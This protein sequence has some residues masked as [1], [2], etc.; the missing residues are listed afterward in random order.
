MPELRVCIDVPDLPRAIEFYTSAFGL[1]VARWNRPHW[2]ELR[3]AGTPIDLLTVEPGSPA[4]ERCPEPRRF[5]R[6]WTPVHVDLV[7]PDLEAALARAVV[8]GAVLERA[9]VDR[10]WG[11]MANLSDPFGHGLCLLELRGRGYDEIAE[12]AS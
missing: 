7:V 9:V 11:R 2:A 1:E 6:H 10:K 3:G 4:S 12:V 5:E 8:A